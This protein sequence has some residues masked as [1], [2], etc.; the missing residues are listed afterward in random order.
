MDI[1]L[2]AS[3]F[4]VVLGSGIFI[5][6]PMLLDR[7]KAK[8]VTCMHEWDTWSSM[9]ESD[10]VFYQI[11]DCKHCNFAEVHMIHK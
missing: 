8:E 5:I 7:G 11:R 1:V 2:W 4:W 3:V 6:L 10:L 9:R